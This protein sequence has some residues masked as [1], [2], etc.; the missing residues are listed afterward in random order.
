MGVAGRGSRAC[1]RLGASSCLLA[2]TTS[3]FL[4]LPTKGPW[5]QKFSHVFCDPSQEGADACLRPW[6]AVLWPCQAL[7]PTQMS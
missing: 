2:E 6:H 3:V 7:V 4:L 1:V 5:E